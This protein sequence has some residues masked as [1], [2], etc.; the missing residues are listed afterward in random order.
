M[1]A[2]YRAIPGVVVFAAALI[3][4]A[5]APG[6]MASQTAA[7]SF[8]NPPVF[9]SVI[10]G[11]GDQI[12]AATGLALGED[13]SLYGCGYVWHDAT[14]YDITV[15]RFGNESP[16]WSRTW[17]GAGD[18]D[19]QAVDIAVA[20]DGSV[21]VLATYNFSRDLDAMPRSL[22][23]KYSSAGEL[24][25]EARPAF[26]QDS[27]RQLALDGAGN[28][29]VCGEWDGEEGGTLVTLERY[30]PDGISDWYKTYQARG[31]KAEM[32]PGDLR[33]TSTGTSYVV[34]IADHVG[35][36][37]RQPYP[38][39][40]VSK[41]FVRSW[42]TD[43]TVRWTKLY[44]GPGRAN[45][46][47]SALAAC[48]S[49]GIYAVGYTGAASGALSRQDM[50]VTRYSADGTRALTRRLGVGDGRRQW[51]ADVAVDDA[52]RIAVCGGWRRTDRGFYVAVL[53]RDGT[54]AWSH[55]YAGNKTHGD[56]KLIAVD[57]AGRMV[58]VGNGPGSLLDG[59]YA[60]G[61]IKA[62][63]FTRSGGLRWSS[64]WPV[65]LV[66]GTADGT[67]QL[68][69]IA[70]WQAS[71]VWACGTSDDRAG[72]GPDQLVLGWTLR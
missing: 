36:D 47:F 45:A 51:A 16:G 44:N 12:D 48:P 6:A 27:P 34:G 69:D 25:W 4:L 61:P 54:V 52:G 2:R 18:S 11:E 8:V 57:A 56:A 26:V 46:G 9:E 5:F 66:P 68:G 20:R 35:L 37:P 42:R 63:A 19:D 60:P 7:L 39:D 72:T 10:A 14:G 71:N 31:Y 55:N 49:G 21:Y 17:N 13:G 1:N 15:T 24:Q 53:R 22:L 70:V 3:L 62:Y 59:G 58:A 65:P 50:L 32:T 64:T 23:L 41:A 28:A 30:G 38:N 33:V 43:G 67:L 40:F 29:Y